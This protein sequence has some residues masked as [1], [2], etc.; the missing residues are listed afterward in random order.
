LTIVKE[1][2]QNRTFT[3]VWLA[4]AASGL[5]HTFAAFI[6]SWLVYELTGSKVA[7]GSIWLFYMLPNLAVQLLAGPF[8]DRWQRRKVMI[9]AEWQ[10]ALV[11]LLPAVFFAQGRLE[12]WHLYLVA[13]LT[14]IAEPLFR[15]SSM[16][17]IPEILPQHQLMRGNS[18]LEGT[19][20]VFMLSGPALGGMMVS[21]LGALSVLIGLVIILGLAGLLLC[22][23]PTAPN[24]PRAVRERWLDQFREG[25]RF[26]RYYPVLFWVG[27]MLLVVNFSSGA[28]H[29]MYLPLVMEELGGDAFK[30]GLFSSFFSV[31]MLLGSA[32]AGAAG[33]PKNRRLVMLGSLFISGLLQ[34]ALGWTQSYTLALAA[35]AGI[36]FTAMLFTINN[37]TFYQKRVPERLRGRVFAVRILMS[38]LGMPLGSFLGGVMGE[39]LGLKIL[40]TILGGLIL[41]A[42]SAALLSP[43]FHR[44]NDNT[45]LEEGTVHPGA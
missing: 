22:L 11:Y 30:Y 5:G 25:L 12:V 37:T 42:T 32:W 1:L 35:V 27:I 2:F 36:G 38:Q 44:L 43:V 31:G 41:L 6:L 24:K 13:A 3:L 26:F 33:E 45:I 16:A 10:R 15:S 40:F 29:P 28:A 14:G 4:Q 18:V 20:Q 21:N 17:Y 19:A 9:F 39:V 34:A 23:I 8:L 7:M